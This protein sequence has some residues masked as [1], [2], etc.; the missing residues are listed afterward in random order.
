[1]SHSF[2]AT[3]RLVGIV[4]VTLLGGLAVL[5]V[6]DILPREM[7]QTWVVKLLLVAGILTVVALVVALLARKD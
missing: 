3:L 7:L 2:F 1:M 5:V 4:A 6:L